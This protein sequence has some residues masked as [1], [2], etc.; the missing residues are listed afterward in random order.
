VYDTCQAGRDDP[1]SVIW[2]VA[3]DNGAAAGVIDRTAFNGTRICY[4]D[5]GGFIDDV[6]VSAAEF[7]A[8]VSLMEAAQA[9]VGCI[10]CQGPNCPP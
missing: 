10:T 5:L 2:E 3:V 4:T 9:A 7:G 1:P 8:C 6:L